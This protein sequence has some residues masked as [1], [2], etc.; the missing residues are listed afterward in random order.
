MTE[1]TEQGV[2]SPDE[3]WDLLR[4]R[5]FGRLAYV[6]DGAP[7]IVPVNY[8]VD[9][10]DLVFRTADG[11]K[12]SSILRENRVAFEV[13]EVDDAAEIGCSVVV[14]GEA[15]V[16]PETEELRLEQVGLRAWLGTDKPVLVAIRPTELTGRR[17][18]LRRP[19]RRMMRSPRG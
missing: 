8:R 7:H 5:E 15:R 2:L 17:Y 4:T 6:A 10:T 9:G 16:L 19:W 11:Q 18:H 14:R 13:D 1:A 12:L 3:C